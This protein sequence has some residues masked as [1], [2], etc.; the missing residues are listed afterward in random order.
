MVRRRVTCFSMP[1]VCARHS[2]KLSHMYE[3]L[4]KVDESH[5][6]ALAKHWI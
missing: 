6:F 3:T 5:A 4:R 1:M 2:W